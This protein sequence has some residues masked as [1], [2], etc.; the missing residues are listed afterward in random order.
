[1]KKSRELQRKLRKLGYEVRATGSGEMGI[2][3]PDGR[4]LYSFPSTPSDRRSMDNTMAELKRKDL[5]VP[6]GRAK[7]KQERRGSSMSRTVR[8]PNELRD[9]LRRV[10][11]GVRRLRSDRH[12]RATFSKSRFHRGPVAP[13]RAQA[14][15]TAR[16]SEGKNLPHRSLPKT[17]RSP[18]HAIRSGS[19]CPSLRRLQ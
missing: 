19:R 3:H 5:L 7:E 2:Y 12:A 9:R 4:W 11:S 16:C 10:A 15:Q 13:S 17:P 1:M 6:V 18:R 8:V 14:H